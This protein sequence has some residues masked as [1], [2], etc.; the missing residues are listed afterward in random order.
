MYT[1]YVIHEEDTP[2][3]EQNVMLNLEILGYID[4]VIDS[5]TSTQGVVTTADDNDPNP[6]TV[7]FAVD[8]GTSLSLSVG[9]WVCYDL[10]I[11]F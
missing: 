2:G 4:Y 1:I 9:V 8:L 3:L 10:N 11:I 5:G 6:G 7:L